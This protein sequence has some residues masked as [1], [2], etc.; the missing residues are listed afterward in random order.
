LYTQVAEIARQDDRPELVW[1]AQR[2]LGKANWALT[3]SARN[4]AEAAKYRDEAIRNYR[5]ALDTIETLFEGSLRADDART[6]FLATT[7]D[8]F[9]EA[10]GALAE[11]ALTNAPQSSASPNQALAHAASSAEPAPDSRSLAYMTEAFQISERGRARSLLDMLG[12]SKAQITEGVAPALLQRKAANMAR[13][14]ELASV[15]TG[16]TGKP[17]GQKQ[18]VGE[19]EAELARLNVEFNSLENQIRTSSPRYGALV[20]PQPLTLAQVQQQVLDDS[21]VL[22]EYN[23]GAERS[24]MWG[25]T[26][27]GLQM[28]RLPP[29][30]VVE[31]QAIELRQ[32]LLPA[33]SRRA[34]AG[35]DVESTRGLSGELTTAQGATGRGLVLGGP[36]TAPPNVAAYAAASNALYKTVVAPAAA[37]I[38]DKRVLVVADGALNYVPFEALVSSTQGV[39]FSVLPYLV[40]TNE[41]VYAPSASVVAVVRQQSRAGAARAGGMLVVADPVFDA[42]D[43]RLKGSTPG[44]AN[45]RAS[46]QRMALSSAIS[47]VTSLKTPG[48]K[49][50]RLGGTRTEAEQIAQLARSAGNQADVWLDFDASEAN[51]ERREL[52]RYRVLHFATHGL[53]DAERPQFTGLALSL[54]GETNA[55]GFLRA[56][57]VFNLKLGSPLVM[58]SACETGLGKERRGE[59]VIGLT[60]AFMYAGAPTVGVSLW[61]VADKSTAELMPDFYKR[62]FTGQASAPAALRAAQVSMITNKRYSAPFYW[63]PF[64]LVGDWR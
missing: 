62:M 42:S 9:D 31:R 50:V 13:Q 32:Q 56:A 45:A 49:L 37:T 59:G 40:K 47:D 20:R 16:V 15:L 57:E 6:S 7:K 30:A 38:K 27:T 19:L 24:Y 43:A 12:D 2:G 51:V 8:V 48:L 29:R 35:I 53:L 18:T 5:A 46:V 58:L 55:D 39:D 14:Q 21:T 4:P 23:L 3:A 28:Y 36:S 34:I 1:G 61:S 54:V 64:V 41:I 60:R 10:A 33:G 63:A 26:R 44:A 25:V 22:L 11:S 52:G 17:D